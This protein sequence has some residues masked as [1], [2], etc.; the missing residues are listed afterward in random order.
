MRSSMQALR[1][2]PLTADLDDLCVMRYTSGTIGKPKGCMHTHRSV[3]CT[4]IELVNWL[5]GHRTRS[6]CRRCRCSM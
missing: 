3:M 1:R 2:G 4:A 5:G 6:C